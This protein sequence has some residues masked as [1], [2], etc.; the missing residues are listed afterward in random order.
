[1]SSPHQEKKFDWAPA[2]CVAFALVAIVAI[3]LWPG[4][5][6]AMFR[7]RLTIGYLTLFIL[8]FYGLMV[9]IAMGRGQ[10]DLSGLLSEDS[11][12]AS[13]AR[14]QLLI[15]TF[16]ISLSLFLLVVSSKDTMSFPKIPTEILTLLGI[17]ASTYGAG[18]ALQGPIEEAKK[19]ETTEETDKEGNVIKVTMRKPAV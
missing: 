15:F 3:A 11:G 18:K 4:A 16:V 13:M 1:M 12:G 6:D 17:S 10:I 19:E 8:F 14:L 2:M 9:L 7:L 5:G